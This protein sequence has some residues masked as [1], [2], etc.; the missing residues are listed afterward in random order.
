MRLRR[1]AAGWTCPSG[2]GRPDEG[3]QRSLLM[4]YTV[5]HIG[6]YISLIA[7]ILASQHF[8][9]AL[10]TNW[11]VKMSLAAFMI[12]GICGAAVGSNLAEFAT[13][14][15]YSKSEIGFWS[16]KTNT[17][18]EWALIEHA[19]FWFGIGIPFVVFLVCGPAFFTTHWQ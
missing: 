17:Y 2:G 9:P 19:A 8:E 1:R 5:F 3:E 15:E 13:W 10:A 18:D 14:D 6:V 12:A 7:A 4:T 11:L 16:V